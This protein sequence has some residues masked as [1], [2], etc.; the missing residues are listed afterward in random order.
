MRRLAGRL[1][2][3]PHPYSLRELTEMENARA[4]EEWDHTSAIL[5]TIVNCR[6][7]RKGRLVDPQKLHPIRRKRA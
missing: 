2:I 4:T 5:A 1:G 3:D 7:F 6:P